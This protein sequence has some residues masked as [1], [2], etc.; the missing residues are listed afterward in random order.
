MA[1]VLAFGMALPIESMGTMGRC[2]SITSEGVLSL[3]FPRFIF[4]G[5]QYLSPDVVMGVL[6]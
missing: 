6:K 2:V 1:V 5:I 3:I 4:P